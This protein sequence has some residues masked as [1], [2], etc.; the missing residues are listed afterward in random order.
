MSFSSIHFPES[1]RVSLFLSLAKQYP[2]VYMNAFHRSSVLGTR[3]SPMKGHC[4]STRDAVCSSHDTV[5]TRD[6]VCLHGR[7]EQHSWGGSA[8]RD[9]NLSTPTPHQGPVLALGCCLGST[10]LPETT[11]IL[12]VGQLLSPGGGHG[13]CLKSSS[14]PGPAPATVPVE[15]AG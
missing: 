15:T 8:Q 10:Q 4:V 7:G 12:P 14:N 3:W 6:V 1:D 13:S 11:P 9:P 2:I 5:S